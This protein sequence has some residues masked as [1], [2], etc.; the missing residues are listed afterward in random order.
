M[1]RRAV[2]VSVSVCQLSRLKCLHHADNHRGKSAGHSRESFSNFRLHSRSHT[3]LLLLLHLL[4]GMVLIQFDCLVGMSN[5][6][7]NRRI[8]IAMTALSL[9]LYKLQTQ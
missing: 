1:A 2:L 9:D 6:L 7:R 8:W 3:L 4:H 5:L